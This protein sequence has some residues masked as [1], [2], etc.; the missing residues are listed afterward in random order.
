MLLLS[1]NRAMVVRG[2]FNLKFFVSEALAEI[3]FCRNHYTAVTELLIYRCNLSFWRWFSAEL[4]QVQ[5]VCCL[6]T[7]FVDIFPSAEFIHSYTQTQIYIYLQDMR[8]VYLTSGGR[9]VRQ[10]LFIRNLGTCCRCT[11]IDVLYMGM[12]RLNERCPSV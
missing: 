10:M 11:I 4:Q 8:E 12:F 1:V 6:H 2:A 7:N 3:F 5:E 9:S